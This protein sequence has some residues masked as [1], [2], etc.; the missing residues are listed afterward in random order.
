MCSD[1]DCM[2]GL[3]MWHCNKSYSVNWIRFLS[4][5]CTTVSYTIPSTH[6]EYHSKDSSTAGGVNIVRTLPKRPPNLLDFH[7]W[8][9]CFRLAKILTSNLYSLTLTGYPS[10]LTLLLLFSLVT[11]KRSSTKCPVRVWNKTKVA[12]WSLGHI[13]CVFTLMQ[14]HRENYKDWA[15]I[16]IYFSPLGKYIRIKVCCTMLSL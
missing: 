13:P 2:H 8:L 3:C 1:C 10:C 7:F 15:P 5:M 9:S 14:Y 16:K 11:S 12:N 6:D 4:S